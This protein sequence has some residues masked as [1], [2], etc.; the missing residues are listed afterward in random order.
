MNRELL[1]YPGKALKALHHPLMLKQRIEY[2]FERFKGDRRSRLG[3]YSYPHQI[4]FLAGM[5][6]GGSTWMKNLLSQIPGYYTRSTPMPWEV[7]YYQDI[8]DSAF[9]HTPV[10]AY[11]LFKTHLNPT[12]ENL[13]CI[14]RN[15]VS[16]IIVTYR[17]FRDA[18][19]ALVYR[20]MAFPKPS[21][22]PDYVD[23]NKIGFDNS[24][25][26]VLENIDQDYIPWVT[27]WM[28][29]T[30]KDKE[31]FHFTKFEELKTDTIGSLKKVLKFYEISLSEDLIEQ[32]VERA[33]GKGNM[34]D[35][36]VRSSVLPFG[37]S[38]NFRSGKVG[39][40]RNEFSNEHVVLAKKKIGQS[41][42]DFG[43][44]TDL[45]WNIER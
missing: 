7:S 32:I 8:C 9:K 15:G 40:W 18:A 34:R 28:E 4:I 41:L 26:H 21:N 19:V 24:L 14:T 45:D 17:D 38:S 23:Y 44:E 31:R 30:K 6:M 5:N 2:N 3:L 22:A 36:I 27:G 33:K 11:T 16:K 25:F 1:Y 39:G 10:N 12:Q 20:L 42:I 35:N 13:D 29:F 37:I 43:Y